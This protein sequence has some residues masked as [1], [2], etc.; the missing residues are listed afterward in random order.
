MVESEDGLIAPSGRRV[1]RQQLEEIQET[2]GLFP[3]LSRKE[4][5]ATTSAHLGWST[6][7]GS[8]KIDA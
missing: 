3:G 6:G 8:N 5:V 7:T 2:V 1:T 4:L